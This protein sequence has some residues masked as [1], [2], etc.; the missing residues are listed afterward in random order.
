MNLDCPSHPENK[1]HSG[2]ESQKLSVNKNPVRGQ[3]GLKLRK[4]SSAD[5]TGFFYMTAHKGS[6][7]RSRGRSL[8]KSHFLFFTQ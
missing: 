5:E 2:R 7:A 8:L 1:P 6:V 4:V 3:V